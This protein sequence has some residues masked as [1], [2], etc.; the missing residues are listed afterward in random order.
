MFEGFGAC[1]TI[2][3]CLCVCV[4]EFYIYFR[5]YIFVQ[6]AIIAHLKYVSYFSLL[7]EATDIILNLIRYHREGRLPERGRG[8]CDMDLAH[9][10]VPTG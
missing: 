7:I 4:C 10:P 8:H 6:G 1:L 3:L 5:G 2:E 9:L